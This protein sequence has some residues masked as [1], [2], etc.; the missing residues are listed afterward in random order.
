MGLTKDD[1]TNPPHTDPHLTDPS[2][3]EDVQYRQA[4]QLPP[5]LND[6]QWVRQVQFADT[7]LIA[8]GEDSA[9]NEAKLRMVEEFRTKNSITSSTGGAGNNTA[10]SSETSATTATTTI[11]GDGSPSPKKASELVTTDERAVA[12]EY[13]NQLLAEFRAKKARS[14]K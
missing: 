1:I 13:K 14:G 8:A 5:A 7:A 4:G 10:Q 6:D 12:A 9:Q 11:A 3:A 2:E